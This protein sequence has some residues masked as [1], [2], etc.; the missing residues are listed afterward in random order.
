MEYK[1]YLIRLITQRQLSLLVAYNILVYS[2]GAGIAH[3]FGIP[4]DWSRYLTGQGFCLS[5][6][7]FTFFINDYFD[8]FLPTSDRPAPQTRVEQDTLRRIQYTLLVTALVFITVATILIMLVSQVGSM[9]PAAIILV[10]VGFLASM[11][12]AIPPIRLI[13]SG[14]GEIIMAFL[15]TL[16]IPAFSYSLLAG[17]LHRYNALTSLPLTAFFTA[18]LLIQQFS[19]YEAD[20]KDCRGTLLIRLGW[21]NGWQLHNILIIL[22]FML[23]VLTNLQG[24]PWHL[25]LPTFITVPIAIWQIVLLAQLAAGKKPKWK[26]LQFISQANVGLITYILTFMF[27]IK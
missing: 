17:E 24:L 4:I 8:S 3:Y 1:N 21:Q 27:W 25:L 10:G 7:L 12:Y 19:T 9:N 18:M 15:L 5:I 16:V 2:L 11:A 20:C 6:M 13:Y 26:L 23:L 22:G 14:A